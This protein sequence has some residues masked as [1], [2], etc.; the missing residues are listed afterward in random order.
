[1]EVSRHTRAHARPGKSST[2]SLSHLSFVPVRGF[3][4]VSGFTFIILYMEV[5]PTTSPSGFLRGVRVYIYNIVYYAVIIIM[6]Q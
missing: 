3:L 2:A 4:G 1:M 5:A 6:Y